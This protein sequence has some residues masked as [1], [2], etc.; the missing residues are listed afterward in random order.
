MRRGLSSVYGFIA[1]YLLTIAALEA[2]SSTIGSIVSLQASHDR[3]DQLDSVQKIEHL[4]LKLSNG[5]VLVTNDGLVPS[6]VKYLHLTLST[7]SSDLSI[8]QKL[9]VGQTLQLT[10]Q[11]A[12]AI[13]AI[14]SLGNVFW[15]SS[16]APPQEIGKFALTFDATGVSSGSGQILSIDGTAYSLGQLPL[17]FNWANGEVHAFAY[18]SGIPAGTGTRI[19]W[20][21]T[22][23][24]STSQG[25]Q[26]VVTQSG[27]VIADYLTQNYL[28]IV[29]GGGLAS[30]PPSPTGDGWFNSGATVYVTSSDVWNVIANQSRSDLISWKVDSATP[31]SVARSGSGTFTTGGIIM[32]SPHTLTLDSLTQYHLSLQSSVPSSGSVPALS[33]GYSYWTPF[34]VSQLLGNPGFESG[35][36]T[37]W[38][39]AINCYYPGKIV[40]TPVHSGTFSY[41]LEGAGQPFCW[42]LYQSVPLSLPAGTVVTSISASIWLFDSAGGDSAYLSVTPSTGACQSRTQTA[43]SAGSWTLLTASS[44]GCSTLPSSVALQTDLIS[45]CYSLKGTPIYCGNGYADDGLLSIT[46]SVPSSGTVTSG[47][48]AYSLSGSTATYTYTVSSSFPTGT[49]SRQLQATLPSAEAVSQILIGDGPNILT[50]PQYSSSG[51]VVNI[52]DSTIAAYGGSYTVLT[53]ATGGF[54][55]SQSGSQTGDGWYDA[56]STAAISA[57]PA[58]PFAFVSWS[59]SAAIAAQSSPQTSVSMS[60]YYT[61]VAE[62][63]VG[64]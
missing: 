53:T 26:I 28:T 55:V 50:P 18:I 21:D 61:V 1:I 13:S 5:T 38:G 16:P 3:A 45:G 11:T 60:T 57:S 25:G 31:T 8:N 23:G 19:R 48:N 10:T 7:S 22:R 58:S 27:Q 54:S 36:P 39:S 41:Q 14:T 15:T 56:G 49:A 4:T 59:G 29:G 12:S 63:T 20:S 34:T 42:G 46:Y 32:N 9:S 47:A 43:L 30:N 24:L 52:P 17:T 64:P 40:T 62:F 44:S 33:F 35:S 6:T 51:G 37:P 2:S